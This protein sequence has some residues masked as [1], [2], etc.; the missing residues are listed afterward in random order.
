MARRRQNPAKLFKIAAIFI[1]LAVLSGLAVF[2]LSA[3]S[4]SFSKLPVFP[5]DSYMDGS[6]LWSHEDYVITGKV[7]NVLLRSDDRGRLLVS[8]RPDGA[9]ALLP[10]IFRQTEGGK[11]P[12]QREQKVALK[13]HLGRAGEILC[14]AY[15]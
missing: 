2:W 10:V 3:N 7:E 11:V 15:E 14:T 6:N 4:G 9:E 1:T 12:V 5:V 8:I 13:V